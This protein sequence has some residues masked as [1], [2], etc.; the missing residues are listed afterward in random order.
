GE[1]LLWGLVERVVGSVVEMVEWT[2]ME[3]NGRNC[4][5]GKIG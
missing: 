3:G 5:G 2:E 1:S 4:A